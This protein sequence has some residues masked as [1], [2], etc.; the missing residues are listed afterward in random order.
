MR[1]IAA[2]PGQL[3]LGVLARAARGHLDRLLQAPLPR[4][5]TRRPRDS[6]GRSSA[7][8]PDRSRRRGARAPRRAGPLGE[9]PRA[10][11]RRS[12]G[13][14]PSRGRPSRA[15]PCGPAYGLCGRPTPPR[16]RLDALQRP[17]HAPRIAQVD[18]GR[19]PPGRRP[20]AA[21]PAAPAHRPPAR[22][23]VAGGPPATRLAGV[24]VAVD[25]GADVQA[26]AADEHRHP[27]TRRR[28][29][30]SAAARARPTAPP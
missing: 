3:A 4:Q 10:R 30:G 23:P 17:Q 11:A 28:S 20:A 25:E 14:A 15:A 7:A 6:R 21:R 13:R 27:A 26:G 2:E 22:R 5:V 12:A 9:Q 18:A 8:A 19:R 1:G 29:P 24:V 16:R